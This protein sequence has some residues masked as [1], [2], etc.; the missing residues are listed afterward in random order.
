MAVIKDPDSGERI[1]IEGEIP[2]FATYQVEG[3]DEEN[4]EYWE[5][6]RV[7]FEGKSHIVID[8]GVNM[9]DGSPGGE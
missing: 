6:L 1:E 2:I 5:E 7:D 8:D 4:D 9:V 3:Y